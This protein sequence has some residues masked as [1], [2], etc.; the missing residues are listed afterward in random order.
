MYFYEL[1]VEYLIITVYYVEYRLP[2]GQ[3]DNVYK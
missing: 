3:M 2:I 1:F